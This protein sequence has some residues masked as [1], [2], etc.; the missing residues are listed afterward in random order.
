M[1]PLSRRLIAGS[2]RRLRPAVELAVATT[3]R[4][5]RERLPGLAAEIAFWTLLSL[6]S[7]LLTVLAVGTLIGGRLGDDWRVT[8]IDRIV[9]VASVALT[10]QTLRNVREVLERL[11]EE[12]GVGIAS[13][14]F[15]T[16]LWVASRAV[17]VVLT[18]LE[19][20]YDRSELRPAW[21]T[22]LIGLGL[23]FA[24]L[25][26]GVVLLPLVLAGPGFGERLAVWV[27]TDRLGLATAWRVAY[28]PATVVVATFAIS[29]LYHVGVPG[30]TPW[31]RD[32]PGAV[33]ASGFWLLGSAGLRLYGTWVVDNGSAYGPLAG[34]IVALLWLWLTGFAVLAG[35][36]LNAQIERKWPT[37]EGEL[38]RRTTPPAE[39]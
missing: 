16:T 4:A 3:D 27:G 14:A 5:G 30:R 38:T 34:P 8:L 17:K 15:L 10:S 19:L 22:R 11:V 35:A 28:W 31:R 7:L 36:A 25:A 26:G 12:G 23:T 20:V 39:R 32:L 1:H 6:P 18:T 9:E 13:F 37:P 29:V 33:L 2:P 21:H 24:A